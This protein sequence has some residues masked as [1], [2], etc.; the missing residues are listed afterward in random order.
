M[1]A[2]KLENMKGDSHKFCVHPS[3]KWILL[4]V[5]AVALG[6]LRLFFFFHHI[7]I[8]CFNAFFNHQLLTSSANSMIEVSRFYSSACGVCQQC[9]CAQIAVCV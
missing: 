6:W 3:E 7:L 9:L 8:S 4:S 2:F 5:L 1:Y